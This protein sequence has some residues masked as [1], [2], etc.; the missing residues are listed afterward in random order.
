V[1]RQLIVRLFIVLAELCLVTGAWATEASDLYKEGRRAEKAGN[2]AQAYLLYSEAAALD[3]GNHLYWLRTEALKGRA[4]LT[5]KIVPQLS[6]GAALPE[7]FDEESDTVIEEVTAQDL[8]DARKP[9]PPTTLKGQPGRKDFDVKGDAKVLF[10]A[11]ARAFGLECVFDGDYQPGKA[12]RFRVDQADYRDALHALEAATGSFLVPISGRLF[13]VVKDTPQKRHEEEPYVAV[14]VPVPEATTPQDLTAMITAVQQSCGIQKV[15]WD[16]QRKVVVMRDAISKILPARLLFEDLLYPRAQVQIEMEM[17]E[18]SENDMME[19]G[20]TLPNS[21]P[22]TFFSTLLHS[23]PTISS[24]LSGM[25]LIG[26]GQSMIGLGIVNSMVVATL[27]RSGANNLLHATLR[28]IDNQPAT[29]HIGQKYP[30]LTSS[31]VGTS[32]VAGAG[33]IQPAPSFTFEDLGLSMKV[34]PQVHGADEVTLALEAEFKL[35]AGAALNGIPVIS[36]RSLKSQVTLRM[37]EWAVVAGLMEKQDARTIAG[38]AGIAN[39]PLLGPLMRTTTHNQE[40]DQVVILL[41]PTLV[42]PP[43]DEVLTHIFRMG[44]ETRPLTPL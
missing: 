2:V 41:K 34:T 20:L 22:V 18:V 44:S 23:T 10:P 28:S 11:V 1:K 25:L 37:G 27:S 24:T 36:N 4:A 8:A 12:I 5:G 26:G 16:S 7:I 32:G 15:G 30:V 42:T 6:S 14:M 33:V 31:Y 40:S 17:L 35:L 43:P 39:V 13:L 19:Y 38:I 29:L 3:P 21:F 9:L